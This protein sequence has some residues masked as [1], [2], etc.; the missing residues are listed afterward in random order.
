MS[1]ASDHRKQAIRRLWVRNLIVW[2]ALMALLAT[3]LVSAYMPLGRATTAVGLTIAAAK[4]AL[5][6][7]LFMELAKSS[8]LTK[9][10]AVIGVLWLCIMFTL[11][12]ADELS[13][14]ATR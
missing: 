9:L 12:F 11:T 3:T 4:A 5:V 8:A 6:V 13:R 1:A 7:L 14:L 2:G 10:V